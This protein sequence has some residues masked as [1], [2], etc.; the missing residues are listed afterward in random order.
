MAELP[1]PSLRRDIGL[2][3]AVMM[4]LGSILGTGVFVSIGVA[5]GVAGPS[6]VL[7]IALAAVVA[8]CNALSSAQL[9][10]SHPVSGG[11][12]EF[13]HLYLSPWLG[14]CAGW[15]FLCA[16]S[17]SA[18]TAALGLAGYVLVLGGA[19]G[20]GWRVPIALGA[21]AAVTGLVLLGI[22]RSSSANIAIVSITLGA[23]AVFVVAGVPGFAR[24]AGTHFA[25]FFASPDG[26]GRGA[27]A[28]LL[29]ATA[30]MFVAYA[31]YARIATMGEEV[32]DPEKT[33]PRAIVLTLGF[34]MAVYLAVGLV[35][36]GAA[37]AAAFGDAAS[38]EGAPLAVVG[39]AFGGAWV[40]AALS[41]GAITAMLGVLLNLVLGLSRVVLAMARR[42]DVP[43]VFARVDARHATP[44]RSV[45]LVGAAIAGLVLI[46]DLKLAWSFSAFSV[47]V[48]YAITNAAALRL[49]RE[50]RRYHP[51]VAW[52]GLCACLGLAFWVE[53]RVWAAGVAMIWIGLG[54]RWALRRWVG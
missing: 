28:R 39:A 4:G 31:G 16:K 13:G 34:A 20:S 2:P 15:M 12:Y 3:G 37:G 24:G 45:L 17:A 46:G 5:A 53:P 48:Y 30:L 41:A 50:K 44:W 22:R 6:V 14:F 27:P 43:R 10:A 19:P 36:I 18:A 26:D 11:T 38:R 7:A 33:I 54:G 29:E 32:R 9:A 42:G 52:C 21:V 35:G 51:A 25:G 8:L 1:V 47:L 23:L 40:A 49:P